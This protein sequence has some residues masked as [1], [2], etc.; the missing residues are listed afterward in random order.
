MK[1]TRFRGR[2][3]TMSLE[4]VVLM[5]KN[6]M[7]KMTARV[8]FHTNFSVYAEQVIITPLFMR[9]CLIKWLPQEIKAVP[10]I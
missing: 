4:K 1:M 10:I 9:E 7:K 6:S 8:I 5:L 2:H 3:K